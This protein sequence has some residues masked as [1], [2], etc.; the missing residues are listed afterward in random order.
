MATVR[1][2]TPPST[3]NDPR[4]LDNQI[5]DN[6]SMTAGG[7]IR[8]CYFYGSIPRPRVERN[9]IRDNES[10]E[11][12]GIMCYEADSLEMH[13][14]VIYNNTATN[15]GGGLITTADTMEPFI[16]LYNCT[17]DHNEA[18]TGFDP[19][20]GGGVF[21]AVG[22]VELISTIVGSNTGGGLVSDTGAPGATITSDY[23][24][25]W[26]NTE[27]DYFSC[28]PGPHSISADPQYC[29]DDTQ[30][31]WYCI[32]ETSPCNGTGHNGDDIGTGW[33]ACYTAESV[34]FYDNF[35]DQDDDG[36]IVIEEWP[37]QVEVEAGEYSM[38]SISTSAH[39]YVSGLDQD[40]LEFSVWMKALDT[41]LG[42]ETR[43]FFRLQPDL[44]TWYHVGIE[45]ESQRGTLYRVDHLGATTLA[46]F[47]VP[48]IVDQWYQLT[49]AAVGPRLEA[50]WQLPEQFPLMLFEV[51]DPLPLAGGTVGLGV[52]WLESGGDRGAQ[53][54][55]FDRVMVREDRT[56]ADAPDWPQQ[57]AESGIGPWVRTSPNP[58][59][60]AVTF[61]LEAS[62]GPA[63][64]HLFDMQGRLLRTMDV[65]TQG[66]TPASMYWDGRDDAGRPVASGVYS[67]RLQAQP[68]GDVRGH[69][70]ILR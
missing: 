34:V 55:H 31:P 39:S 5:Y 24:D 27:G 40:D 29:T 33:V 15:R 54:T 22:E 62:G 70:I 28:A 46:E 37:D 63:H 14:C 20:A 44:L 17:V 30:A 57:A 51:E 10:V 12:G 8:F 52:A 65:E 13:D 25:V 4:I 9:V 38:Y 3:R 49:I 67:W 64:V 35:S 53:H 68:A 41:E 16:G 23:C 48:V 21:A 60:G 32:H 69:V 56:Y 47:N 61:T 66:G 45:T 26:N 42:G 11:G 59:R 58:S 1:E 36:W 7:G 18:S 43:F 2:G 19:P 50:W 6:S